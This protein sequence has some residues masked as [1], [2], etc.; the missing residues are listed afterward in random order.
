M[1]AGFLN[2]LAGGGGQDTVESVVNAITTQP[3]SPQLAASLKARDRFL[4][5]LHILY[6]TQA[7][8][9]FHG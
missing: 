7:S 1:I 2:N 5:Y 6:V 3:A 4:G 9:E 8:A